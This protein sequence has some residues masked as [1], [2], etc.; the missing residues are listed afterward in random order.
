MNKLWSWCV[1]SEWGFKSSWYIIV[2]ALILAAISI[3]AAM[4]AKLT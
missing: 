2:I 3:G 1:E 4:L